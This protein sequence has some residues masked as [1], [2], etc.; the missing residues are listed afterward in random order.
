MT[1]EERNLDFNNLYKELD[2]IINE[3]EQN[4]GQSL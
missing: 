2:F 1:S 4:E 3:S